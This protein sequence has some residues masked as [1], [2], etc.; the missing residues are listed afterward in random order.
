MW[1]VRFRGAGASTGYCYGTLVLA[2]IIFFTVLLPASGIATNLASAGDTCSDEPEVSGDVLV[3]TDCSDVLVAAEGVTSIDAGGGD[4]QI[5]AQIGVEEIEAGMG[6]D[7]VVGA[8]T[9]EEINAGSG[10]DIVFG[11]SIP[12]WIDVTDLLD[13]Q[14][15]NYIEGDGTDETIYGS[16]YDA[17]GSDQRIYARGGND[18]VFGERGNDKLFGGDGNDRLYGGVGDD[19]VTGDADNDLLSGGNG[20]DNVLGRGGN[21]LIRGDTVKDDRHTVPEGDDP[22]FPVGMQGGEGIDTLSFATAVTPGF[23]D[24]D[25]PT[26]PSA[27]YANFPGQGGKR[28]VYVDLKALVA[29]NGIARDGGGTDL[30][31]NDFEN[32]VGSPF[33]DFIRGSDATSTFH[34]GNV[35]DG[36]GGADV[37]LGMGGNDVLY[38]S[39]G[40]DHLDGGT[41]TDDA[42]WGGSSGGGASNYC[43]NFENAKSANCTRMSSGVVLDDTSKLRTGLVETGWKGE[44]PDFTEAYLL[45]STSADT[46]T[47]TFDLTTRTVKFVSESTVFDTTQSQEGCEYSNSDK[48]ATCQWASQHPLDSVTYFGDDQNDHLSALGTNF[49]V[50][51]SLVM[52][53]GNG[54]DQVVEGSDTTED[55][56]IDGPDE[57]SDILK[58]Y[59]RTDSVYQG[60]GRDW[61][62]GGDDGD[63][64]Y[65]TG[66]CELNTIN[67]GDGP[68]NN[69]WAALPLANRGATEAV[70]ANLATDKAG[71][72]GSG[73]T[74]SC[75]IG[76]GLDEIMNLENIEGSNGKDTL[77]GDSDPNSLLGRSGSD[78]I[79]GEG[80]NDNLHLFSGDYD[81]TISCGTGTDTLRR[82]LQRNDLRDSAY[83][84]CETVENKD[85]EYVYSWDIDVLE[86]PNPVRFYRLGDRYGTTAYATEPENGKTDSAYVNGVTLGV[87]GSAPDTEDKAVSLDGVNDYVTLGTDS[88]PS[89]YGSGY[90]VEIWAKFD[91]AT[92]PSGE[93]EGIFSQY[94]SDLSKGIMLF[95]TQT[96]WL[97]FGTKKS[98]GQFTFTLAPGP[99]NPTTEWHQFVGTLSGSTIT[100]YVDGNPYSTSWAP[101]SVFPNQASG[102]AK[103]LGYYPGGP[104]YLAGDIDSFAIYSKALTQCEVDRHLTLK[105]AG[106]LL[107]C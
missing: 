14:A 71:N 72:T 43:I 70:Y 9:V 44:G 84:G 102:A 81:A 89:L 21:D 106:K 58:G 61:I 76:T 105:T 87:E 28:G 5:V 95:R 4:D 59:G 26:L 18:I 34:G 33:P 20:N 12:Q 79:Y 56:L 32:V 83:T 94:A 66:I 57:G 85:A 22:T 6:N 68:D 100:L 39:G 13:E 30:I 23:L 27:D 80:G 63:V 36:G 41:G 88:D 98:N 25:V 7:V 75:S 1:S 69:T 38:G 53:G 90:S 103:I 73:G 47:T 2:A 60:A 31:G 107:P 65:S 29:S 16:D 48:T 54:S 52:M 78:S 51:T 64:M 49:Q 11:E 42:T 101:D 86:D 104:N 96:G 82:D 50:P 55:I 17:N 77:Y 45:G 24:R 92:A 74:P 40:S 35:I 97:V 46:V 15:S 37:I 91:A 99:S 93:T 19:L 3:G 10:N 8:S 67:G 62:Y